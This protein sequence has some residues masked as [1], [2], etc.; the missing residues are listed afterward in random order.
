MVSC[1]TSPKRPAEVFV[2][3]AMTETQIQ[4]ANTEADRGNYAEALSLLNEAW[5][6][7]VSTDRPALRVRVSIARGNVLFYQGRRREAVEVWQ[8]AE[9]EAEASG[10]RALAAACRIYRGR[11]ALAENGSTAQE[12]LSAVQ[13]DLGNVK[14]DKLFTALAWTVIGLAEKELGQFTNAEKSLKNALSIHEGGR[15][16]EQA[17][18][19]WYLIASVRSVAEN[20]QGAQDA[21]DAAIGFDRRAENTFALG[22]DWAAKGD[23]FRKM[24]NETLAET[25]WH[26]AAEIFRS[27]MLEEQALAAERRVTEK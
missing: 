24:E 10:D 3:Q 7:A 21:L 1:S 12:V 16:L 20:Y 27:L 2:L 18:Y 15:Y 14:S 6:M 23:V 25:A 4:M 22:M 19:D 9:A 5:R 17:G 13:A 11:S 8:T 26:R